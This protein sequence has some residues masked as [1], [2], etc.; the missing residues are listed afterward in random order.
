MGA[1]RS[2]PTMEVQAVLHDD[3]SIDFIYG[4]TMTSDAFG[5]T[6]GIENADG[7]CGNQ[8]AYDT[9]GAVTAGDSIPHA[10]AS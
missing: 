10:K 1:A 2:A 6:I 5:A 8:V 3:S 9:P 4:P 7:S